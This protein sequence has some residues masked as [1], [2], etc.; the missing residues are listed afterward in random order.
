M[1]VSME[2]S[3]QTVKMNGIVNE[4]VLLVN[5]RGGVLK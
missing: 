2:L 4:L 1:S 3:E 5:G